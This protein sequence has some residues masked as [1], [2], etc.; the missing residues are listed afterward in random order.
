MDTFPKE[1]RS[2]EKS[3]QA[4]AFVGR[5]KA[6]NPH[7]RNDRDLLL[8]ALKRYENVEASHQ[9]TLNNPSPRLE[10]CPKPLQEAILKAN[11]RCRLLTGKVMSPGL[12]GEFV[13]VLQPLCV[14]KD[15]TPHDRNHVQALVNEM[16][17]LRALGQRVISIDPHR[18][19]QAQKAKDNQQNQAIA[20]SSALRTQQ[21]QARAHDQAHQR[22]RER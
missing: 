10:S 8:D 20:Q 21:E 6:E 12:E 2:L 4:G 1:T 17:R 16:R 14:K 11:E 7:M 15:D 9:E 5:L 13:K 3:L 19:I 22:G 18:A